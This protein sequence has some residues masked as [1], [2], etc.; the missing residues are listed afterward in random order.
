MSLRPRDTGYPAGAEAVVGG[1]ASIEGR[2]EPGEIVDDAG[3]RLAVDGGEGQRADGPVDGDAER[4]LQEPGR[5][6]IARVHGGIE[7]HQVQARVQIGTA[8]GVPV[9]GAIDCGGFVP[10]EVLYVVL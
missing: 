10:A 8:R 7:D 6:S 3:G 4:R 1:E 5:S 9:I 2:T